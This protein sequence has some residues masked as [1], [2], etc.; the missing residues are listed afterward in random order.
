MYTAYYSY[1]SSNVL[2]TAQKNPILLAFNDGDDQVDE[3]ENAR[4]QEDADHSADVSQEAVHA[5]H[6]VFLAHGDLGLFQMKQVQHDRAVVAQP[7][8]FLLIVR[9][10]LRAIE[11]Q[12]AL[13]MGLLTH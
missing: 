5:V 11:R 4:S 3:A 13:C 1:S 9:F 12:F 6:V 10:L 7:R 2:M 8:H